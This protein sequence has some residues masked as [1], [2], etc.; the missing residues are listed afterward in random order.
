MRNWTIKVLLFGNMTEPKSVV[1]AGFD[2][3]VI[4]TF[5]FLGFLLQNGRENILVDTGISADSIVDGKVCGFP[6][7]GGKSF[8][9]R[10]LAREKITPEDISIVIYTHLH[11]DHNG[12]C[13]LFPKA[14]H[15]VQKAEWKEFLDPLPATKFGGVYDQR[16]IK[17]MENLNLIRIDGDLNLT[18]GIGLIKTPGHTLGSQTFAVMTTKGEYYITGDIFNFKHNAFPSM[19]EMM[20]MDGRIIKITPAPKGLGPAIPSSFI[21]DLYTWYDSVAKVQALV[22]NPESLITSHEPS[23]VGKVFP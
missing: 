19:H 2:E 22:K 23:I 7:E 6:C 3:D 16:L 17:T 13:D 1:T 4:I 11:L 10:E 5:P 9:E 14:K 18:E 12:N 8:V 21:Q 15:I 20:G